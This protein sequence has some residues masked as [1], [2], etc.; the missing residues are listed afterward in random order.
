MIPSIL[1]YITVFLTGYSVLIISFIVYIQCTDE[2][3]TL[4][5]KTGNS[6]ANNGQHRSIK[7]WLP[8]LREQLSFKIILPPTKKSCHVVTV[9]GSTWGQCKISNSG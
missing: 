8:K 2:V 3:N 7:F 6:D 4:Y 5:T 9:F 1:A